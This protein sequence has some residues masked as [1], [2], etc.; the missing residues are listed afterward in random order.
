VTTCAAQADPQFNAEFDLA[1]QRAQTLAW[2]LECYNQFGLLVQRGAIASIRS[3]TS[4]GNSTVCFSAGNRRAVANFTLRPD[5]TRF[6]QFVAVD[7]ASGDALTMPLD[8]MRLRDEGIALLSAI[9]RNMAMPDSV[10]QEYLPVSMRTTADSIE[11]WL[12]RARMFQGLG[13]SVGGELG[14]VFSPDGRALVRE[15]GTTSTYRTLGIE[16]GRPVVITSVETRLPTTSEL[17]LAN[18]LA[19]RGAPVSL[20]TATRKSTLMA[21]ATMWVHATR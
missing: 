5:S 19:T 15:I 9:G 3:T 1:D 17:L 20:Q 8:T 16:P 13:F 7:L 12:L 11:I 2:T 21:G 18:L 6:A 14:Y 10:S 4:V